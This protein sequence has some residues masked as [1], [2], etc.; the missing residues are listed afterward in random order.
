MKINDIIASLIKARDGLKGDDI[1]ITIRT[2]E[3]DYED[4]SLEALPLYN[5][6]LIDLRKLKANDKEKPVNPAKFK[7]GKIK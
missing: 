7:L 6:I 2:N 1:E 5:H 3:G 4:F